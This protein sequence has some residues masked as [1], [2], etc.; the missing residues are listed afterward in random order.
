MVTRAGSTP[1]R[2]QGPK[3]ARRPSGRFV[4]E[5]H[6]H[7]ATAPRYVSV[8]EAADL[9]S[10]SQKT[11][12]RRIADGELD[13]VRVGSGRSVRIPADAVGQLL[14]PLTANAA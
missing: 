7:T 2:P 9:L 11:I 4:M 13:A 10:V 5:E 8:Q 3:C 1:A 14:R 12:R 6:M